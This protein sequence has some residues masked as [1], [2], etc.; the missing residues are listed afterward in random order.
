MNNSNSYLKFSF[1]LIGIC[2]ILY[3]SYT[4]KLLFDKDLGLIKENLEFYNIYYDISYSDPDLSDNLYTYLYRNAEDLNIRNYTF[5]KSKNSKSIE[6]FRKGFVDIRIGR[7]PLLEN[8][9]NF[10]CFPNSMLDSK[11]YYS[12]DF[13]RIAFSTDK[14]QSFFENKYPD[15]QLFNS[16]K[17]NSSLAVIKYSK[18]KS[19]I[20][21]SVDIDDVELQKLCRD[22]TLFVNQNNFSFDYALIPIERCR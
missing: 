13:S 8:N 1:L 14:L 10:R 4:V 6:V 9:P 19:T 16:C 12:K 3:F 15:Y 7:I 17:N 11:G 21:C 20:N 18:I 2:A 5:N 22:L